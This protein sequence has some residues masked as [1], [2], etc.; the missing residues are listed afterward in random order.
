MCRRFSDQQVK[1]VDYNVY[2][3]SANFSD[4]LILWSPAPGESCHKTFETLEDFR[5]LCPQFEA[6]SRY[7]PSY[8]GPLFKSA[9]LGN[10]ELLRAFPASDNATQLPLKIKKLLNLKTDENF[11]GAY[12]PIK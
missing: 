2:V 11:P 12:P 3:R 5:N 1:Q 10:Y 8:D 9:K 6:N 4:P 7:F